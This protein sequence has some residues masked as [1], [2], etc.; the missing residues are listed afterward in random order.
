MF[1]TD[2]VVVGAGVIGLAVARA[3]ALKGLDVI[4]LESESAI[5][6]HT[7]SRNSEV[8]HA[9]IY[10]PH[11]SLKAQL[12][13]EGRERLYE[14]C[15]SRKVP[16]KQCGKLIVAA[17]MEDIPKLEFLHDA[18]RRNSVDDLRFIGAD[19]AR[20][21]EPELC[22]EAA[23]LSPST[24]IL[25]THT[26]ML[27]LL[28][29]AEDHGA[30]VAL[31]TP[32]E[33]AA[34]NAGGFV[35]STGGAEPAK[36]QSRLLI[37]AAGLFA[38][39]VA[40][41]IEGL[42]PEHVRRTYWAKG[43]YFSYGRRTPFQHL[44]YPTPEP[45]GLGVH[46]TLDLAGSARFGPDVCWVDSIEYKVDETRKQAFADAIKRYWPALD[47]DM[48]L[49]GYCGIRPKLSGPEE[50]IKDFVI[51]WVDERDMNGLV[52]LFG[53]ESP[54]ITAS[55]ALAEAIASKMNPY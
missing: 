9:G 33:G 21:L 7:S 48:L 44:I 55:L 38:T 24:G 11:G 54:G 49:P 26:Y 8:I 25:D 6:Q 41:R 32:F 35:V 12:C 29:E 20:S 53:I 42:S 46:L 47:P 1:E 31:K 17:S 3:L 22:C 27:A 19:E 5:G 16:F 23:L 40:A 36:I 2:A 10:Y 4:V 34:S 50:P 51:Q 14:F 30:R 15:I 13:V 43:N 28:G 45:G 39:D 52:N 37:N 18:G